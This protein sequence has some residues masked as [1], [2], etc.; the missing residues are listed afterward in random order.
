VSTKGR[1]SD[2]ADELSKKKH[3]K[4][5]KE[6]NEL[7]LNEIEYNSGLSNSELTSSSSYTDSNKKNTSDEPSKQR[8]GSIFE[9]M[10]KGT[11]NTLSTPH[12]KH[13][14]L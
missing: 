1:H 9:Q 14:T 4:K 6:V 13:S 12:S 10:V 2:T 3:K 11:S 7:K 8:K 5:S